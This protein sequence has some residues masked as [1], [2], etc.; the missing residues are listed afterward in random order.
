MAEEPTRDR[1]R[2]RSVVMGAALGLVL[3]IL[4]SVTAGVPF[5]PEV[6][7][8]L[9]G[10]VGWSRQPDYVAS[11]PPFR[12]RSANSLRP[13]QAQWARRGERQPDQASSPPAP[14]LPPTRQ[15]L[16]R[17]GD[18]PHGAYRDRTGD[19][20]LAKPRERDDDRRRLTRGGDETRM[21]AGD[22][23]NLLLETSRT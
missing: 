8:L 17:A 9:G 7:L 20:R 16:T 19:L 3:G 12:K 5:A 23:P 13:S 11:P 22:Q 2:I 6:G 21:G 15:R 18:S 4:V 10:L 14:A 1:S